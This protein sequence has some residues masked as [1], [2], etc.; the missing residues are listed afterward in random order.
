MRN[1]QRSIQIS[2]Y[3]YDALNGTRQNEKIEKKNNTVCP[4]SETFRYINAVIQ[5]STYVLNL[6]AA[7]ASVI[8]EIGWIGFV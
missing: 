7:K 3:A 4:L 5:Y 6:S 1:H 2:Q 8:W